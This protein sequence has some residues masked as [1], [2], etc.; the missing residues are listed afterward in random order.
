ME[1]D[2]S[3]WKNE[4][5]GK[6]TTK[7]TKL[8]PKLP[9]GYKIKEFNLKN[10]LQK[11]INLIKKNYK[12]KCDTSMFLEYSSEFLNWYLINHC[13]ER[14]CL[15][16]YY[17]DLLVGFITGSEVLLFV[18]GTLDTFL[19]VNFLCL[20]VDH[21]SRSLAPILI[22]H[23]T[24]IANQDKIFKAIF[25]G[26]KSFSFN[27]AKINYFHRPI[28]IKKLQEARYLFYYEEIPILK[29]KSLRKAVKEDIPEIL[30]LY[31]MQNEKKQIY[32]IMTPEKA[33][34]TFLPKNKVV[35]TFVSEKNGKITEFISY[36][37]ISTNISYS[38]SKVFAAYL[39]HWSSKDIRTLLND[40]FLLLKD[41]EVDVVNCL[42][43][44]D[45]LC[46]VGDDDFLEGTGELNYSFYNCEIPLV[47]KEDINIVMY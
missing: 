16:L 4:P 20:H 2:S 12:D 41:E 42:G 6:K 1:E 27:F 37:F 33:E 9:E 47:G 10:D 35:T 7:T 31:K 17:L 45:N 44:G 26:G 25:T 3:F 14:Y 13:K 5:I 18:K 21:R 29:K 11:V 24:Y 46:F 39:L 22:S 36:F 30:E 15:N 40:S 43:L 19:G 23:L 28:N 38:E 32:E 8:P 34:K